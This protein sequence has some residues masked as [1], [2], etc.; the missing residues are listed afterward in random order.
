MTALNPDL[1]LHL[2]QDVTTICHC[3]RLV[4]RDGTTMGFTDHDRALTCDGTAFAPDTG[5]TASEARS[6]L[7]LGIDT[8]DVEGALSAFDID[9][10]DIVGGKFD[11]A[12][13]ETLLVNWRNPLQFTALRSAVIG[14][15]TRSDGRFVAELESPQAALDQINGRTLR[16]F[17]DAELGDARCGF[18]LTTP[19]FRAEA[20]LVSVEGNRLHVSG[21][22]GYEQ[23]WFDGGVVTWV[24]GPEAGRR[25]RVAAHRAGQQGASLTLWRET[26]PETVAGT[27]IVVTAGCDKRFSTCKAKFSNSVNFQGFPHLPGDDAAYGYVTESQVHDGGPLVE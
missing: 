1:A 25:D 9:E 5:L 17:C 7:G 21:L 6:S 22:D 15:I 18:D 16:R 24:A 4:R 27:A 3:W 26:A 14:K 2:E 10:A 13:V 11:G 19:G 20:Q 8:V 23:G 12:R